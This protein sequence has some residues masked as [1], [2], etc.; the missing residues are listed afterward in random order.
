[1]I[2]TALAATLD[3]IAPARFQLTAEQ[4]TT[5]TAARLQS[6][7]DERHM[8]GDTKPRRGCCPAI[9]RRL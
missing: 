9:L 7:F 8:P 1:M 5:D 2:V 4:A 3:P 6:W